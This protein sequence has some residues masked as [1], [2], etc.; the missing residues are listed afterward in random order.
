[1]MSVETKTRWKLVSMVPDRGCCH[2]HLFDSEAEA[3]SWCEQPYVKGRY[4]YER[5][6]AARCSCCQ[7]FHISL[8]GDNRGWSCQDTEMSP[9]VDPFMAEL[10]S[11]RVVRDTARALLATFEEYQPLEADDLREALARHDAAN[12][13]PELGFAEGVKRL[14]ESMTED[15]I[16]ALSESDGAASAARGPTGHDEIAINGKLRVETIDDEVQFWSELDGWVAT[17]G[18][19]IRGDGLTEAEAERMAELWNAAAEATPEEG[20]DV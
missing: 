20:G 4:R 3:K 14:R 15:E 8:D 16:A 18:H 10:R 7:L 13:K 5:V 12:P 17:V 1:M 19:K 11:L 2:G 9:P 6:E